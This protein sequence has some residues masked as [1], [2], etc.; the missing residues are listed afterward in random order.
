[1]YYQVTCNLDYENPDDAIV[2]DSVEA[3]T[4]HDAIIIA[5][6]AISKDVDAFINAMHTRNPVELEQY[7][8]SSYTAKAIGYSA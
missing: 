3:D 1:M 2:A 8:I 4:G 5:L 6:S 7:V